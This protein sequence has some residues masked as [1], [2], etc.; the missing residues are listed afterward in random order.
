MKAHPEAKKFCKRSLLHYNILHELC[1]NISATGEYTLTSNHFSQSDTQLPTSQHTQS[2]VSIPPIITLPKESDQNNKVLLEACAD[3]GGY[4]GEGK[5]LEGAGER[6]AR[7]SG[8]IVDWKEREVVVGEGNG[9]LGSSRKKRCKRNALVVGSD[10]DEE[11]EECQPVIKKSRPEQKTTGRAIAQALDRLSATAQT[12]QRS[13][14]ELAV[15]RLQED[16][17]SIFAIDELVKAFVVMENEVKASIFI[18]LKP[19]EARDQWLQ[20]AINKL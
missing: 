5:R 3:M 1:A 19:G 10:G 8:E 4:Q 16:Y 15:E 2:R 11:E 6:E 9:E 7:E 17:A 20:E 13:K 18:S 14:V 12:I